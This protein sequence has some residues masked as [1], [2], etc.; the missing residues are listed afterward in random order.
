M[1]DHTLLWAELCPFQSSYVKILT[2]NTTEYD[3]FEESLKRLIKLK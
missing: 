2:L 3:V 1:I